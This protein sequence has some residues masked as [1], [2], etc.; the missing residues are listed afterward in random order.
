M[1]LFTSHPTRTFEPV[2]LFHDHASVKD[3]TQQLQ[4][5]SHGDPL[6]LRMIEQRK[7]QMRKMLDINGKIWTDRL[8]D[9]HSST[10]TPSPPPIPFLE[11]SRS[12]HPSPPSKSSFTKLETSLAAAPL[13]FHQPFDSHPPSVSATLFPTPSPPSHPLR[14]FQRRR[15]GNLPKHITNLLRHWLMEHKHHPYPTEDQKLWLAQQTNLTVNQISNW[16][17]NARRRILITD[18]SFSPY[19]PH[20]GYRV[21]F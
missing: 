7:Q 21:S 3:G 5:I 1:P 18:P 16:F 2:I 15:R 6:Y 20:H 19:P 14:M 4:H 10:S 13:F 11:P 8:H 12:T 17:I 9:S